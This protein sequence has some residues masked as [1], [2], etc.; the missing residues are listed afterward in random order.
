MG[1]D[2]IDF[3]IVVNR[4]F[5]LVGKIQ[6][7]GIN[8]DQWDEHQR[9]GKVSLVDA[10]VKDFFI[11][12]D[13]RLQMFVAKISIVNGFGEQLVGLFCGYWHTKVN[14]HLDSI[15]VMEIGAIPMIPVFVFGP[16]L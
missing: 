13:M 9:T 15:L 6:A 7:V 11:G 3:V 12:T 2:G 1:D 14:H 4:I 8:V 16:K 5:V 10:I